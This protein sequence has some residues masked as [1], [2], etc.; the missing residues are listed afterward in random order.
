VQNGD[1][2]E[3]LYDALY[4]YYQDDMPYGV[5]KARTGDPFEWV[6]QRFYNDLQGFDMV[7]EAGVQVRK[8]RSPNIVQT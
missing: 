3:P 6:G 7:D 1:M 4:D 8:I 5:K 2:S